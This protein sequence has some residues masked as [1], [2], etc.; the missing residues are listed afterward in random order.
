MQN[1]LNLIDLSQESALSHLA[2]FKDWNLEEK[3][4]PSPY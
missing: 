3:V 2:P 1:F 4:L